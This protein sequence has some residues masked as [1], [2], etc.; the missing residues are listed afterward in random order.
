MLQASFPL[1]ARLPPTLSQPSESLEPSTDVE[2]VVGVGGGRGGWD[3][4]GGVWVMWENCR[5]FPVRACSPV[6]GV[7]VYGNP[8][9]SRILSQWERWKS[10]VPENHP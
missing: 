3:S 1:Y 2:V 5:D 6:S 8:A 10:A 4:G 7:G 9:S